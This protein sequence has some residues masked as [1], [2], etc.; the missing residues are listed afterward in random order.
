MDDST[1]IKFPRDHGD[2]YYLS[3]YDWA[4]FLVTL[5]PQI[6]DS[7]AISIGEVP[8][9][10]GRHPSVSISVTFVRSGCARQTTET[11]PAD[12]DRAHD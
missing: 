5:G 10:H 11:A 2:G 3:P 6:V 12:G 1:D 4:V 9:E 8:A 7:F